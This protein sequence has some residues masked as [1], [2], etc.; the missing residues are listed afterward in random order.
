M[1]KWNDTDTPLAYLITFR[2]YGTWLHGDE[3]GSIDRNHNKFGAPM[4][5]SR[6]LREQQ[7][8]KKLKSLPFVL[9]A[10]SRGVVEKAIREVCAYRE[11]RLY[12]VNVRTNHAHAVAAS[13]ASS[14]KVLNDM[15]AYATRRLREAGCWPHEH[16]PWVDK[17]SKRNLWNEDHIFTACD[18]VVNRQGDALPTFD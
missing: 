9:D 13:M 5:E 8:V 12:A 2:T 1:A 18:Y 10:K 17:G 14:D 15:K 3:R 16:S 6:I 11:W 7:Q 4:A